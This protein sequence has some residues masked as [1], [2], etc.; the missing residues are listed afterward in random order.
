[1][2]KN[3]GLVMAGRSF[4]DEMAFIERIDDV[5]HRIKKGFVPDMQVC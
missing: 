4:E 2:K 1:M 3:L 5:T